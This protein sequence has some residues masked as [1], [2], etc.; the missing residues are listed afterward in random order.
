MQHTMQHTCKSKSKTYVQLNSGHL[1]DIGMWECT[2]TLL[3][4]PATIA[5]INM[6]A[7][8]Q[9]SSSSP[10]T[11]TTTTTTTTESARI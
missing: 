5:M 11:T 2:E 10:T 6:L 1:A 3:D 9:S 8:V 7:L 4:I